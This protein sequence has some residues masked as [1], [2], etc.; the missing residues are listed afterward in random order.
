MKYA[1]TGPRGIIRRVT[2]N[3]PQNVHETSAVTPITEEQAALIEEGRIAKPR[4]LYF[5]L[6]G[7]LLTR[8]QALA[9]TRP[10]P[11]ELPQWRVRAVLQSEG[12][13]EQVDALIESLPSPDG[14]VV[15]TAWHYGAAVA[16]HGPTVLS[17]APALGLSDAQIDDMFR[18]A[19]TLAV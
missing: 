18:Q 6:D 7:E 19:A 12:L 10:A 5:L 4:I 11:K 3:E 15:R 8:E 14:D 2:E 9:R 13:L 17:L 1:I 16:R